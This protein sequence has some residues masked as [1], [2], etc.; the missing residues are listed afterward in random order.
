VETIIPPGNEFSISKLLDLEVLVIG[1]G[2][3]R[4]GREFRDLFEASGFKLSKIIPTKESI[5]VIEG[6]RP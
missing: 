1:G 3:E 5:S 6:I 2:R 4:T